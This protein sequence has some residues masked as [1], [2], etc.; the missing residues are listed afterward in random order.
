MGTKT[1]IEIMYF[2]RIVHVSSFNHMQFKKNYTGPQCRCSV[3][4]V[5]EDLIEMGVMSN[6]IV[7]CS[8]LMKCGEGY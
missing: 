6:F 7:T 8:F 2:M 4:V 3:V 1:L 5:E